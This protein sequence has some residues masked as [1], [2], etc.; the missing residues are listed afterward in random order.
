MLKIPANCR[1]KANP[2][3][4]SSQKRTATQRSGPPCARYWFH[5]YRYYILNDPLLTDAEYDTLYKALEKL[6]SENP[7]LITPIL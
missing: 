3:C 7:G 4:S 5:E 6:E 2:S 1:I